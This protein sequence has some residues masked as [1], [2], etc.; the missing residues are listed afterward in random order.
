VHE[1]LFLQA[2]VLYDAATLEMGGLSATTLRYVRD[3]LSELG[4]TLEGFR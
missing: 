4:L 3:A 2:R 1:G